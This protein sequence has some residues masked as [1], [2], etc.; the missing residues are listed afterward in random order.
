MRGAFVWGICLVLLAGFSVWQ[1]TADRTKVDADFLSLIGQEQDKYSDGIRDIDAVRAL[2]RE[3]GRQAIFVLS[4]GDRDQLV[5]I[6]EQLKTKISQID[7]TE[8]ITLPG[9]NAGRLDDLQKLYGPYASGLLSNDDR[10]TLLNGQAKQLYQRTLQ[11]LYSPT[12]FF[13][14]TTLKQ[15]PFLLMPSF[16]TSLA[17][18]LGSGNDIATKNDRI[19][20]PLIVSLKSN[21]SGAAANTWV[22]QTNRIIMGAH[23]NAPKLKIFKTGQI[24]FGAE[25]A[26]AAKKDVQ[27][28]AL[29]ATLGIAILIGLTFFSPI[30]LIGAIVV[31]G[32][33][34]IAGAAALTAF[35]GTIHAIALVFGATMIGIS[36]DY[37]LHFLVVPAGKTGSRDRFKVIRNGLSLGLLTSIIGF[38]ALALSPTSL[39]LQIAV[40]SVAGLLSAYCTVKFLLP[41]FPVREVRE[42]API[43]IVHRRLM[44]AF[45]Y[46]V[47]S[48]QL[49]LIVAGM[50]IAALPVTVF[51]VPGQDDIRA[52]GQSNPTL[53]S[54]TQTISETL[55]LGGSPAFIR[56]DGHNTQERLETSEAVRTAIL[57][58]MADGIIEGAIAL[59]DFVPSIARQRANRELVINNLYRPFAPA[60][61]DALQTPINAPDLDAPYLTPDKIGDTLP[62]LTTLQA[63]TSDIIRLRGVTD[64]T[65]VAAVLKPFEHAR[66]I[67]P[68]ETISAQFAEYRYWAYIAL[69]A[70]LLIALLLASLRYGLAK[71]LR[72]FSAPAGAVLFALI[73]GTVFGVPISFFTTMAMFLV[74]AIGADY[75]LFLSEGKDR[76]QAENT[77]LAVFLSLISSVLAF[78]LLATS[79]VP[80]VSDIGTVIAFGLV[81][82]W[83]LAFWMT[84]PANPTTRRGHAN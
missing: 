57:P 48:S 23:Q 76:E 38:V 35:F 53:L 7:G 40:Y 2:L 82:A 70:V 71:G 9:Q 3:N 12:S 45:S 66:F 60:L 54:E 15:D 84:A 42:D 83:F 58:L 43:A 26:S 1:F 11:E 77:Q 8:N 22:N 59:S 33:G 31:V 73:G 29:I 10:D 18:K 17:A 41:L 47:V 65:A 62:E 37:A 4:H 78:G 49:R 24:F 13:T 56:I 50:L 64:G 19:Y 74:V 67:N 30:P 69:G 14:S 55:G 44:G 39:L 75:V 52:L 27:T 61:A 36:I 32:S 20:L 28:I 46:L 21:Q 81:G 25:E 5:S 72:V 16:L 63:G 68:P 51:L 34:L 80:L 6:A 79:S